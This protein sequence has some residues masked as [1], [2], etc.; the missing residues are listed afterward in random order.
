MSCKF[1]NIYSIK[2]ASDIPYSLPYG[3]DKEWYIEA[4]MHFYKLLIEDG[5]TERAQV[6]L[7]KIKE[8]EAQ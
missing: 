7:D 3:M 8:I 5:Q 1:E 6:C 4:Y 2:K